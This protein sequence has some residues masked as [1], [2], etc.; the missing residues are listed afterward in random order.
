MNNHHF[1]YN[2]SN[3]YKCIEKNEHN[4]S[5]FAMYTSKNE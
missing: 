1:K 5:V 2:S 3:K 4:L